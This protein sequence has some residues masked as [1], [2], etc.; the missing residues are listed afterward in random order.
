MNIDIT[1]IDD[2]RL[3]IK[4]Y[5]SAID[6]SIV[7]ELNDVLIDSKHPTFKWSEALVGYNER[8]PGYRDCFDCKIGSGNVDLIPNEL[9][10]LKNTYFKC[11][12]IITNC[13]N[14]YSESQNIK[15]EFMEAINFVKY[16]PGEHFS[17][18]SDHGFS[19]VCTV[20]SVMYLN[21]DYE[22]GE[23]EFTKLGFKIKPEAGDIVIFPS[24]YIF[25]HASLPV[26][27]GTKY[28]AVTM[29]DYN[30]KWHKSHARETPSQL[31]PT[32]HPNFIH[33]SPKV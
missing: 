33:G 25:T 11:K 15:M 23:L 22:G 19:Y 4:I 29:F 10:I 14:H 6:K 32:F 7:K 13:V 31:P 26:I 21:D 20:S 16:G 30:D 24:T 27:S 2:P 8:M 5:K 12:E 9:S 17:S 1:T 3:G 18:H 28:S